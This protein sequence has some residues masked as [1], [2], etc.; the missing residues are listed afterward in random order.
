MGIDIGVAAL[1]PYFEFSA[2]TILVTTTTVARGH[3]KEQRDLA[4]ARPHTDSTEYSVIAGPGDVPSIQ[5]PP[6]RIHACLNASARE[7]E[8]AR[9][10]R[11]AA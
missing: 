1:E 10:A 2:F 5:G 7:R 3:A 11:G 4:H 9:R 6:S 8:A